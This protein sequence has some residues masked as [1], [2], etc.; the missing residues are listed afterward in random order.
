MSGLL[1]GAVGD[2]AFKLATL[3]ALALLAVFFIGIVVSMLAYTDWDTFVAAL[4]SEEI[5]FAIRLSV[6]TATVAAVVSIL[7]AV[8]VAY[9]N[10]QFTPPDNAEWVRLAIIV[11]DSTLA[12]LGGAGSNRYRNAGVVT[13]QIFVPPDSFNRALKI[14]QVAADL[15]PL[16]QLGAT[17]TTDVVKGANTGVPGHHQHHR[18]PGDLNRLHVADLGKLMCEPGKYPVIEK[19]GLLFQFVEVRTGIGQVG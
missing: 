14:E 1:K 6:L 7:I 18:L 10:R 3:S 11:G 17:V 13:A 5:L 2:R 8:P 4:F 15:R 9:A 19:H 16:D 12:G